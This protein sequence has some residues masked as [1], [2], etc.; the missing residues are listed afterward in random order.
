MFFYSRMVVERVWIF[1][2]EKRNNKSIPII[3]LFL[4][5]TLFF[6]LDFVG[7]ENRFTDIYNENVKVSSDF[8]YLQK[9]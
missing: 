4:K 9:Q 7:I 3:F 2:T 1:K 6:G 8:Q 5:S